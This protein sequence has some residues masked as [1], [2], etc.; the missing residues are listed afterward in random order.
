MRPITGSAC[1]LS[2]SVNSRSS[3]SRPEHGGTDASKVCLVNLVRWLTDGGFTLLD[4][5]FSTPHLERLGC[6]EIPRERYLALLAD[7]VEREARWPT[8]ASVQDR[9]PL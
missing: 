3:L 7:A 6:V 9:L 5:Q 1:F 4:T 2:S 8:D